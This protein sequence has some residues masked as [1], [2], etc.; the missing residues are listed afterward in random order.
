MKKK[1]LVEEEQKQ[2]E[3]QERQA[4]AQA[5]EANDKGGR[6]LKAPAV[7]VLVTGNKNRKMK[8]GKIV[9]SAIDTSKAKQIAKKD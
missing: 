5:G 3:E 2:K 6:K 7:A 8:R 1:M 4:A 9:R